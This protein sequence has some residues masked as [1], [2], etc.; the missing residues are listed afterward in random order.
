MLL[1]STENRPLGSEGTSQQG[2]PPLSSTPHPQIWALVVWDWRGGEWKHL[3]HWYLP[4]GF[5]STCRA[6]FA[7]WVCVNTREMAVGGPQRVPV[8]VGEASESTVPALGG[9]PAQMG[10]APSEPGGTFSSWRD[11]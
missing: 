7:G 10:E 5:L 6:G 11:K 1:F 9:I 2:T 8:L 4:H 3:S